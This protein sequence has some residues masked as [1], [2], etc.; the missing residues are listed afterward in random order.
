MN[1][2]VP[3]FMGI[4]L[5]HLK[6]IIVIYHLKK[7]LKLLK[8][9]L[10]LCLI[11]WVKKILM[12]LILTKKIWCRLLSKIKDFILLLISYK[13]TQ[14]WKKMRSHQRA[15]LKSRELQKK[16]SK[17]TLRSLQL[18]FFEKFVAFIWRWIFFKYFLNRF[19]FC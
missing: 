14:R 16:P 8:I 6:F 9:S 7:K 18:F 11:S 2:N 12:K 4:F 3:L 19:S 17:K 13:N 10:P 1:N 5:I 15:R